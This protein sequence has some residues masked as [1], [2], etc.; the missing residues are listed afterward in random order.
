MNDI[1]L[2]EILNKDHS[3]PVKPSNEWNSII[4]KMNRNKKWSFKSL[5]VMLIPLALAIVLVVLVLPIQNTTSSE[6]ENLIEFVI[7][8]SYF[9]QTSESYAWVDYI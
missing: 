5:P 1:K 9:D 7:D 4:N 2:K 6:R 3:T 8:D